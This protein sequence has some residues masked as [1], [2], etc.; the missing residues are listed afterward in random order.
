MRLAIVATAVAFYTGA[1]VV[2][3][4]WLAF[5]FCLGGSLAALAWRCCP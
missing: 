4:T 2:A 3:G 5:G 1:M